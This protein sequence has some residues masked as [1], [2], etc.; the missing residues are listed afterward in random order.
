MEIFIKYLGAGKIYKDSRFPAIYL[1]IS[2]IADITKI[3]IPLFDKNP[4]HGVKQFDYLD[5]RRVANLKVER[6]HLT[7]EGLD[8]IRSIKSGMNTGRKYN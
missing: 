5:W 4:I 1:T 3:I 6:K 8:L 7:T 2:K